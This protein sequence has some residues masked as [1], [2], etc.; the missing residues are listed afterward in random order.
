MSVRVGGGASRSDPS[1]RRRTSRRR[2][3]RASAA[4]VRTRPAAVASC[5]GGASGRNSTAPAVAARRDSRCPSASCISAAI[6]L[7]SAERASARSRLRSF[8]ARRARSRRSRST[9]ARACQN[10]PQPRSAACT[11]TTHSSHQPSGSATGR[12][13]ACTAC[14]PTPTDATR[15]AVRS[16]NHRATCRVPVVAAG[17]ATGERAARSD[18]ATTT[19]TECRDQSPGSRA[20]AATATATSSARSPP[21]PRYPGTAARWSST[22]QAVSTVSAAMAATPASN[23]ALTAAP[24]RQ[25]GGAAPGGQSCGSPA[26]IRRPY[27]RP[28]GR[29][30]LR[31]SGVDRP[32]DRADRYHRPMPGTARSGRLRPGTT[33]VPRREG[34]S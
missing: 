25:V 23:G 7:R 13:R 20:S 8:S 5:S 14:A 10:A 1:R 19:R 3:S 9:W 33:D 11:A 15:T 16:G 4:P 30:Y 32:E 2:S 24:V 34:I 27:V 21:G 26:V 17:V 12:H 18:S 29:R 28:S 22:P 31:K 6:R